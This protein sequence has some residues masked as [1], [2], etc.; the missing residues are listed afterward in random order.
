MAIIDSFK[1]FGIKGLKAVHTEVHYLPPI[2][3]EEYANLSSAAIAHMLQ[4]RIA[5]HMESVLGYSVRP[6]AEAEKNTVQ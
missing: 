3:Y 1:P 6:T 5:D 2:P 4:E